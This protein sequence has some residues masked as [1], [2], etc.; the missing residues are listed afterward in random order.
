ML[1]EES[2][3]DQLLR[4]RNHLVHGRHER[5]LEG[6]PE[7]VVPHEGRPAR[8]QQEQ[9]PRLD[10]PE[11]E[12]RRREA[13]EVGQVRRVAH[14]QDVARRRQGPPEPPSPR[15]PWTT[16]QATDINLAWYRAL[17]VTYD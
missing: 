6:R 8:L 7:H 10:R 2:V 11:L 13:G 17:I 16:R 3:F 14:D 4:R 1:L 9:G 15:G 5:L 12:R